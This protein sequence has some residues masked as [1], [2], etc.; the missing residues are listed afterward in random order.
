MEDSMME[1][2]GTREELLA[3]EQAKTEADNERQMRRTNGDD[4][5]A[6]RMCQE[7]ESPETKRRKCRSQTQKDHRGGTTT[8]QELGW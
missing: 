2:S 3:E 7:R 1:D 8:E 6:A 5:Q 4:V